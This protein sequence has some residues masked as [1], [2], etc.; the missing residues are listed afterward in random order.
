M[1]A[2]SSW[3]SAPVPGPQLPAYMI[4]SSQQVWS[5]GLGG[6]RSSASLALT[7]GPFGRAM[8]VLTARQTGFRQIWQLTADQAC[9]L[10]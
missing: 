6:L 3:G 4:Q 8:L 10:D 2:A 9:W 7:L 5:G 1:G